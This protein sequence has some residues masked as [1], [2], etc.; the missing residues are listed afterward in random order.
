MHT[1][2]CPLPKIMQKY[3]PKVVNA[4]SRFLIFLKL[5]QRTIQTVDVLILYFRCINF[6]K[7]LHRFAVLKTIKTVCVIFVFLIS[8]RSFAVKNYYLQN[9]T[10]ISKA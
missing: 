4:T 1:P 10:K 9:R 6:T 7:L 3:V 5:E 2:I 8:T